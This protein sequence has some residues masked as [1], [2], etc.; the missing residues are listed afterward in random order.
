M[1]YS[2]IL[3]TIWLSV[4]LIS[5]FCEAYFENFIA[6]CLVPSAGGAF[7]GGMFSVTPLG[8]VLMFIVISVLLIMAVKIT[9]ALCK[10]LHKHKQHGGDIE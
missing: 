7:I 6:V 2:F 5:I 10:C 4:V 9:A 1:T 8:Q 3:P